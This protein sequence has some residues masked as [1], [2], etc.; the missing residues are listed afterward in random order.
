[1]KKFG[2]IGQPLSH[3]FSPE[4]HALLGDYEYKLY[5]LLPEQLEDFM[6]NNELSG[7][8]VTIPYKSDILPYCRELS[9]RAQSV[10]CVNTVIKKTDGSYFGDNTDYLGFRA[11]L[12]ADAEKVRGKKVLILGNGGTAKAVR[13]VLYDKGI[14]NVITVSRFGEDNYTNISSHLDAYL[15]INTTPI[16]MYPDNGKTVINLDGFSECSLVLDMIYNPAKTTLLLQAEK[17]GIPCRNGLYMLV[18]Q[19]KEATRLFTGEQIPNERAAEISDILSYKMKNITLIGMPGCGKTT[20]GKKLA[21]ITSRPF[22]D[23]DRIIS[24]TA[25]MDIPRIF[26]EK[27]EGYLRELETRVLREVSKKSGAVIATGGGI[28]TVSENHELLRQNSTV[29]FIE[30]DISK[31]DCSARP[32]SQKRNIKELF[33][34]RQPLYE[35][36]CDF[37]I[38]NVT[39]EK[40]ARDISCRL[41]VAGY[42]L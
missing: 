29:V 32:L 40:A 30:R 11:L 16:G 3:S 9:K 6:K 38:Y 23:T 39:P 36:V 42:K 28:V 7:F 1:M 35:A 10:G 33:S 34:E 5:P 31:L 25:G 17:L 4:I 21:G 27:G 14:N 19:A 24:E 12:G 8:N 26:A 18:F 2:L 22:Y 37:K 13:A 15:I 41:Q 20:I